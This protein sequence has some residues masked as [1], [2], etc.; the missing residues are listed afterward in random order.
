MRSSYKVKLAIFYGAFIFIL[1]MIYNFILISYIEQLH[2]PQTF[3]VIT[4]L[5]TILIT[6]VIGIFS[7][8]VINMFTS[9]WH[10][11]HNAMRRLSEGDFTARVKDSG[12]ENNDIIHVFNNMA[13]SLQ[14]KD[15]FRKNYL[16]DATHEIKNPI[17][18]IKVLSESLLR[19]DSKDI[20]LYKDFVQ[21][22]NKETDRLTFILQNLLQMYALDFEY[23]SVVETVNV[24]QY[25]IEVLENISIVAKSKDIN[26]I[27]EIEP[28]ISWPIRKKNFYYILI[29]LIDN[30]IKYSHSNTAIRVRVYVKDNFLILQVEDQGIGIPKEHIPYVTDNFYRAN[31]DNSAGSGL[32]LSVVKRLTE[33]HKGH[34]KINSTVNEGTTVS[35]YLPQI[36]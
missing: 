20:T 27:C 8:K 21:D 36:E 17:T 22:I 31:N 26:I 7:V 14:N 2:Q 10:R 23:K 1:L 29:N 24:K 16:V 5:A 15:S 9:P 18:S 3:I 32:G 13:E 11:V 25:I 19:S 28:D 6:L 33:H 4:T 30:S 35:I 34:M 12:N